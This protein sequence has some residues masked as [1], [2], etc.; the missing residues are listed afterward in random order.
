MG[1][2]SANDFV[3]NVIL[4]FISLLFYINSSIKPEV[5][6]LALKA[7]S[8]LILAISIANIIHGWLNKKID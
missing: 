8:A 3:L 2:F 7:I 5:V 1:V 6:S 4:V